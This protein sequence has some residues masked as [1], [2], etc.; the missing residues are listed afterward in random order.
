MKEVDIW[1]EVLSKLGWSFRDEETGPGNTNKLIYWKEGQYLNLYFNYKTSDV[2]SLNIKRTSYDQS[3]KIN[4][5][6]DIFYNLHID[7]FRE[8][9]L[10]YITNQ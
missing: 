8:V 5:N 3:D 10:S 6:K 7:L 1:I 9:K 4:I 2:S